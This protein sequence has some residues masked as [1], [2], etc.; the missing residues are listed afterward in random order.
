MVW[1]GILLGVGLALTGGRLWKVL[2]RGFKRSPLTYLLM[3][4]LILLGGY[5]GINR[6]LDLARAYPDKFGIYALI[7]ILVLTGLVGLILHF[8]KPP[9]VISP[10]K[11]KMR[12]RVWKVS[13]K[14]TDKSLGAVR[15]AAGLRKKA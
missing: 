5:W 10:V 2:W 12:S 4:A 1:A 14:K 11:P 9:L 15:S 8:Q 13:A 6:L 7:G 3:I